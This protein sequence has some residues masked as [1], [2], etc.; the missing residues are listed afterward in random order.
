MENVAIKFMSQAA[1]EILAPQF[2]RSGSNISNLCR[3][4][5]SICSLACHHCMDDAVLTEVI[6]NKVVKG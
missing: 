1:L 6:V 4:S 2:F 3:A 5:S